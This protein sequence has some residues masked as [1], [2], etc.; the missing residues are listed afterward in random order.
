MTTLSWIAEL[1][2]KFALL[3]LEYYVG[4]ALLLSTALLLNGLLLKKQNS[5]LKLHLSVNGNALH[6]QQVASISS[7]I[8]SLTRQL[9]GS[10]QRNFPLI[11]PKGGNLVTV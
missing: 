2:Q 1:Q 11:V 4:L 5:N 10:F 7:S 9:V 6:T 3:N 8:R